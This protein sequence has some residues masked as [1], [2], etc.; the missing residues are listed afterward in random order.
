MAYP[1]LMVDFVYTRKLQKDG[2]AKVRGILFTAT[3]GRLGSSMLLGNNKRSPFSKMSPFDVECIVI[4]LRQRAVTATATQ[5]ERKRY[6]AKRTQRNY[7]VYYMAGTAWQC[8]YQS[9]SLVRDAFEN[10]ENDP[11]SV[12]FLRRST[13]VKK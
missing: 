12:H 5:K 8:I 9:V 10:F 2:T 11:L 1:L 7:R 3:S 6:P 13:T 4:I